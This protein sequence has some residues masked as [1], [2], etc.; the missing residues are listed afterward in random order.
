MALSLQGIRDVANGAFAARVAAALAVA[1]GNVYSEAGFVNTSGPTLVGNKTLTFATAS[2]P[3]WVVNGASIADASNPSFIPAAAFV[4]NVA[5]A[6]GTVTV[7]ISQPVT[8]TIG[9]GE[10]ISFPQH[11]R[12]AIFANQ[13]ANQQYNLLAIS[14]IVLSNT[15][16]TSEG[17]DDGGLTNSIPDADLQFAVNSFFNLFA[18]A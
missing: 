7:T 3:G 15:T 6:G 4:T 16:L 1:A 17:V 18:G 10:T 5:T 11:T 2:F 9:T 14:L 8:G 12:R 13:I